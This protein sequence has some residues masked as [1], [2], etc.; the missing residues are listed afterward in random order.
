MEH[1]SRKYKKEDAM[2]RPHKESTLEKQ[3][4]KRQDHNPLLELATGGKGE[5]LNAKE[6]ARMKR[7]EALSKAM[8]KYHDPDIVG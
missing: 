8:N 2:L 6:N 4:K 5:M 3:Q 7:K 1:M